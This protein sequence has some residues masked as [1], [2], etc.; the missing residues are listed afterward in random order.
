MVLFGGE[1]VP[2]IPNMHAALYVPD[3][4]ADKVG[5]IGG[6]HYCII[7]KIGGLPPSN[8]LLDKRNRLYLLF[9]PYY[10]S[11]WC[12]AFKDHVGLLFSCASQIAE[13]VALVN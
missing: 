3:V 6:R 12:T 2:K 11:H 8:Q 10:S 13:G 9:V 4:P 5:I 7:L 1:D